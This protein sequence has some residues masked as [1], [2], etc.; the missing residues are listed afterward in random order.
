M[1]VHDA[2]G[3]KGVQHLPHGQ[4]DG[5]EVILIKVGSGL[6]KDGIPSAL[7][8]KLLL[9]PPLRADGGGLNK[10]CSDKVDR[11]AQEVASDVPL[12]VTEGED[13]LVGS[14]QGHHRLRE[15]GGEKQ[16]D[17][18]TVLNDYSIPHLC[19]GDEPVLVKDE[20]EVLVVGGAAVA[21]AVEAAHG[22]KKI[23]KLDFC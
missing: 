20:D 9:G 6:Q 13:L 10:V 16:V 2:V 5:Q 14:R 23:K 4:R 22:P 18:D 11:G 19:S 3:H 15:N 8:V 1:L 17:F 7:G 21:L 12:A